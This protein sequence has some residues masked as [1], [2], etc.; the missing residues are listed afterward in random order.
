MIFTKN[1]YIVVLCVTY[2][3]LVCLQCSVQCD[4]KLLIDLMDCC[5]DFHL[6]APLSC[7]YT[8]LK[9]Q[10]AFFQDGIRNRN[11]IKHQTSSGFLKLRKQ[12][13]NV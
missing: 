6:E 11:P 9:K 13:E 3:V 10:Y 2:V 5:L 7:F 4:R 12:S 8:I 1:M